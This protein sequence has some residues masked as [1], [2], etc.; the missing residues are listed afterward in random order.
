MEATWSHRRIAL[1]AFLAAALLSAGPARAALGDHLWSDGYDA[2]DAVAVDGSGHIVVLGTFFGTIDLGGGPLSAGNFLGG[3]LFLARFDAAGN[4]LWS[5]QFTPD[6]SFG[7]FDPRVCA[8]AAGNIYV[9]GAV[10]G[11][12]LDLGGGPIAGNS[13]FL[14]GFDPDGNHVWSAGYGDG[15]V[16]GLD[17]DGTHL[18]AVGYTSGA[19]GVDFGGGAVGTA[20]STDAFVAE[21]T[22]AG[23]HVWSAG[24]GDTD[25][26]GAFG[27]SIDGSGNVAVVGTMFGTVDFGGGPL[28]ANLQDVFLLSLTPAGAHAWSQVLDGT[29]SPG[30]GILANVALDTGPSGEVVIAGEMLQTVDFGGGPLTSSGFG[31][32]YVAEFTAGGAHSWS[33]VYGSSTGTEFASAVSVDG[34]GNVLVTGKYSG[35]TSFGGA[36][37][38]VSGSANPFVAIYDP[39][40]A[41]LFSN[42]IP[43]S[44]WTCEGR[45]TAGGDVLVQVTGSG[46]WDFGGGPVSGNLVL[47]KLE[48]AAGG[49]T[50]VEALAA[51]PL[52][53]SASPNPFRP[54]TRIEYALP[55]PGVAAVAVYDVQGRLVETLVPART[56]A[57]GRHSVP[58]AAAGASGVY[59]VRLETGTGAE[60][61]RVVALR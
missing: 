7:I 39:A 37:F 12:S 50:G 47:A 42:G 27:V 33:S 48:G 44:V 6:Q 61:V 55:A 2:G 49:S 10:A 25:G 16:R 13:I 21:L 53:L 35:D 59:F 45:F 19:G 29:F 51:S 8:D 41:H 4:H 24:Y 1:A 30:G 15:R 34:S 5:Q 26:Q 60:T 20:G 58:F 32:M 17:T 38:P 36:V 56:H 18:V 11:G 14:A 43:S 22:T 57:A 28:V 9:G 54:A 52:G 46:S 40:G 23:A 3:D 31:D